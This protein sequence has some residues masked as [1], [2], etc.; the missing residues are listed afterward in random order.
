MCR[1]RQW[2]LLPLFL[3]RSRIN[4]PWSEWLTTGHSLSF[5]RRASLI[6]RRALND[7]QSITGTTDRVDRRRIRAHQSAI[8]EHEMN[9]NRHGILSC[10]GGPDDTCEAEDTCPRNDHWFLSSVSC[11]SI[12]SQPLGF[13]S[14]MKSQN[15]CRTPPTPSD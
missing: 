9:N 14:E 2:E 5:S 15:N 12:V 3:L 4:G 8:K 10:R 6:I 7:P 11:N 13:S 1:D